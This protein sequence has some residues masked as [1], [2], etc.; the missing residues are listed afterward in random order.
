MVNGTT[1]TRYSSRI[2]ETKTGSVRGILVELNSR[3]LEQVEVF[4]SIPYA[5]PPIGKLRFELPQPLEPWKGIK[6]AENFASVCPQ[7]IH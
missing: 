4:R 7:V 6:L 2:V 1:E 5:K 3:Y